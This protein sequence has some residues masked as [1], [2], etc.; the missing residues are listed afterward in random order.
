MPA[1]IPLFDDGS[2]GD[3]TAKDGTY[4]NRFSETQK[5][6]TYVFLFEASGTDD[7]G[8]HFERQDIVHRHIELAL[9]TKSSIIEKT[10]L[11]TPNQY[12]ITVEPR[13]K[14][15]NHLG[16]E[17]SPGLIL[18]TSAGKMIGPIK[19]TGDGRYTQIFELP[20]D[21]DLEDVKIEVRQPGPAATE[22]V[23]PP[24]HKCRFWCWLTG[25]F[26]HKCN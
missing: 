11:A 20:D 13:D 17:R 24:R 4:T 25:I 10:K 2:H 16:P 3:A 26:G 21:I 8:V 9:D 6:G 7:R 15:G 5:E 23:K 12:L 1:K 22:P 18:M 19:D 14:F